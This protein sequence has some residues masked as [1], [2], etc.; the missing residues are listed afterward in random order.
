MVKTN[1]NDDNEDDDKDGKRAN[2]GEIRS[3][4][5]TKWKIAHIWTVM[6]QQETYFLTIEKMWAQRDPKTMARKKK[7]QAT[8]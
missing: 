2:E 1:D 4:R 7:K 6:R 3:D 5:K 8:E